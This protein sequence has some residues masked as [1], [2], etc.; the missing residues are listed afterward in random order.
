MLEAFENYSHLEISNRERKII[1]NEVF[2]E[3]RKQVIKEMRGAEHL[4]SI[5]YAP[6]WHEGVIGIVASKLVE[7]F[8]VPAI[9]FTNSEQKGIIKASARSAGDLDLFKC[10]KEC[11]ESFHQIWRA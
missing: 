8:G 10:L 1:Q 4:I 6:E 9:V 2:L 11:E 7:T 3:A 5:V